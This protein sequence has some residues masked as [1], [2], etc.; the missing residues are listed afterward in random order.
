MLFPCTPKSNFCCHSQTLVQSHLTSDAYP[1]LQTLSLTHCHP[2]LDFI[3]WT[4]LMNLGLYF[5]QDV[6]SIPLCSTTV[7]VDQSL[8]T[9]TSSVTTADC[10]R[11]PEFSVWTEK[12]TLAVLRHYMAQVTLI[13]RDLIRSQGGEGKGHT[14]R[15]AK[16]MVNSIGRDWLRSWM[17]PEHMELWAGRFK[18]KEDRD[19]PLSLPWGCPDDCAVATCMS[20]RMV[21]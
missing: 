12:F 5:T 20:Q 18:Q 8:Y 10:A 17:P 13:Q 16:A 11:T 1:L 14:R 3:L 4:V 19:S 21:L 6:V 2:P 7:T 15:L 9:S